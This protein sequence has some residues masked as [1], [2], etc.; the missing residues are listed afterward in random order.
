[1]EWNSSSWKK[2]RSAEPPNG[3]RS[4]LLS[5]PNQWLHPGKQLAL[6]PLDCMPRSPCRY[7]V[8]FLLHFSFYLLTWKILKKREKINYS[9]LPVILHFSD[10]ICREYKGCTLKSCFVSTRIAQALDII[11]F[12]QHRWSRWLTEKDPL[13]L[14]FGTHGNQPEFSKAVNQTKI[15]RRKC[16]SRGVLSYLQYPCK[17]L[18]LLTLNRKISNHGLHL[19][20]LDD[21][22]VNKCV[23]Q[24]VMLNREFG[25]FEKR[26]FWFSYA[27]PSVALVPQKTRFETE[28]SENCTGWV[29]LRNY[30]RKSKT[31]WTLFHGVFC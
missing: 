21:P 17:L 5:S 25:E 29:S 8:V 1:M 27:T 18:I 19:D 7:G 12:V 13:K 22:L 20:V 11:H 4:L 28:N 6:L 16:L 31:P 23:N 14:K 10:G 30:Y 3:A 15:V 26:F 9:F 24:W 2:T